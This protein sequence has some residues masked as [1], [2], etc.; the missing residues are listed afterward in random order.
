MDKFLSYSQDYEDIILFSVLKDVNKGFYIDVGANDPWQLSVTKAFYEKG[1]SGINIEPLKSCYELL[2]LDRER[3]INLN[4]GVGSQ[5]GELLLYITPGSGAGSTFDREIAKKLERMGVDIQKDS[6]VV[7]TLTEICDE[8]VNPRNREIHFCKIDVEGYEKEVLQGFDLIAF[9]PWIIVMESAEPGTKVRSHKKWEQM[10]LNQNYVFG[11]E[12]GVN[13]YYV[14]K[15]SK[16][17]IEKFESTETIKM[18]YDLYRVEKNGENSMYLI[19]GKTVLLP[20]RTIYRLGK[21]IKGHM[22]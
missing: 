15:E 5:D 1:W 20:L 13:R 9:R 14:R 16:Y 7:K 11:Y 2:V 21:R 17:L 19:A 8:Y 22:K 10:L 18:K 4:M 12:Y 6:V 3:D